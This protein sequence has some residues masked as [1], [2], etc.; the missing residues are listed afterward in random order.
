MFESCEKPVVPF[1]P[2]IPFQRNETIHQK[3][4]IPSIRET[5]SF[6]KIIREN[7]VSTIF[8][9]AESINL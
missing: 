7:I 9:N 8:R 3:V 5:R 2:E 6:S 4:S 1:A